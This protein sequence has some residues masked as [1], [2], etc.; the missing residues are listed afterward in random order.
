MIDLVI[1]AVV[2]LIALGVGRRLLRAVPFASSLE[3]ALYAVALALG[4]FAYVTLALGEAG[5]L[6]RPVL[7]A[8]LVLG[9]GYGWREMVAAAAKLARGMRRWSGRSPVAERAAVAL[10]V[11]L[12]ATEVVLVLAPPVGGD[13]TKYQLVYPRLYAEAHRIV[14]TPWSFWG[15]FQ[16]LVN[17]LFTAAFVLRGDV[18]ARLVNVDLRHPHGARDLR[19]RTTVVHARGG[20][21]GG[22]PLRHHAA[23][24]DPHGTGLGRVRAHPL[25]PAGAAAPSWRGGRAAPGA[26]SRSAPP[27]PG[28]RPRPS[29]SVSWFRRCSAWW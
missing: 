11:L 3:E 4:L 5:L 25:R 12:I 13:Q 28:S 7:I 29:S 23:H 14:A 20:R 6:Y 16:Y 21:V 2:V 8:V 19:R 10:G 18:L 22:A 26:G 9:A 27:W 17:M 15:Y 24:R 1:V